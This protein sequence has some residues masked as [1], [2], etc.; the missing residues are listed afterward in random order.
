MVNAADKALTDATIQQYEDWKYACQQMRTED[1]VKFVNVPDCEEGY[2][3]F[4]SEL[5]PGEQLVQHAIHPPPKPK[6]ETRVTLAFG[7][8]MYSKLVRLLKDKDIVARQKSVTWAVELL[9]VPSSRV[10]CLAAGFLPILA[11]M[12]VEK[13]M[14]IRQEL[15]L[16]FKYASASDTTWD[17]LCTLGCINFLV[18]MVADSNIIL[19]GNALS[20]L[21]DAALSDE[22]RK[23]LVSNGKTLTFI[24]KCIN[25]EPDRTCMILEFDLLSKCVAGLNYDQMALTELL[26][27]NAVPTALEISSFTFLDLKEAAVRFLCLLCFDVVGKEQAVKLNA[28]D[29]MIPYLYHT[30]PRIQAFGVAAL[31]SITINIDAKHA[32]FN[33][34]VPTPSAKKIL[35][36]QGVPVLLPMLDLNDDLLCLYILQLLINTAEHPKA[37]AALKGGVTILRDMIKVCASALLKRCSRQAIQQLQFTSRPFKNLAL[38]R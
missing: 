35:I 37:R 5:P 12:V 31:M 6:P 33:S 22:V 7:N 24:L 16:C 23:E 4:K 17:D 32:M 38:V 14:F 13:D 26:K 36:A 34:K 10:R 15:A 1:M 29:I 21:N 3:L 9:S 2:P 30:E 25:K 28:V 8:F 19:R 11:K 18:D 20:A 27:V